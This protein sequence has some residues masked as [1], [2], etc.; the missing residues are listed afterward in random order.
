[1]HG[2]TIAQPLG[3]IQI[4]SIFSRSFSIIRKCFGKFFILCL[5]PAIINLVAGFYFE[6]NI[7]YFKATDQ[8]ALVLTCTFGF[9]I[10]STLISS[11]VQGGITFG[12]YQILISK[13]F[14]SQDCLSYGVRRLGAIIGTSFIVSLCM[15]IGYI[16][17]V[18]P[19]VVA[20]CALAVAIPVCVIERLG[21]IGSFQRSVELTKGNRWRIFCILIILHA[22]IGIIG[23][24]S[25]G[26]DYVIQS[27]TGLDL[28]STKLFTI[29]M[30]LNLG[31]EVFQMILSSIVVAVIYFDLRSIKEGTN[32]EML[33][34]VFD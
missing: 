5:I 29:T 9:I 28:V 6:K 14:S 1:M 19:G 2:A 22:L 24:L 12:S 13:V 11:V 21:P 33:V 8:F 30:V 18:I 4:G 3:H 32:I 26:I 7:S 10:V 15:A 23:Y 17:F 16:A 20:L 34:N 25:T 31:V 27:L